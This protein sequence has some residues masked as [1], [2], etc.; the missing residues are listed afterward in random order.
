MERLGSHGFLPFFSALADPRSPQGR[1]HE[2]VDVMVIAVCAVVCGSRGWTDIEFFGEVRK[3]WFA[4]F[5]KLPHGI[6]SRDTFARIFSVLDAEAFG[7]C[8]SNWAQALNRA[9]GG[10][11]IAIDG[12]TLRRSFDKAAKKSAIHLVSA[13]AVDN[14]LVLGQVKV[15]SKSNEITAIPKLL[16]MLNLKGSTVT[17]D[18][19]GCQTDIAKGVVDKGGDYIFSLKGN[20]AQIHNQVR[21]F[22]TQAK[23]TAYR[24]IEHDA[25]EVTE[26]GHGRIEERMYVLSSEVDE[27]EGKGNW[28]NLQTIGLVDAKRTIG[29]NTTQEDRYFLSSLKQDAEVFSKAVRGH[30]GIENTLH[31]CLDVTMNEDQSRIRIENCAENFALL[32]KIA[33]NLLRKDNNKKLSLPR[34]QMLASMDTNYLLNVLMGATQPRP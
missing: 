15:D 28:M 11:H 8:F 18:A 29:E 33:L 31:W 17:I 23:A 25:W 9:L 4:T 26:K 5:L 10:N 20:H 2:L 30:W 24:E 1:R 22:F 32:R 19:M 7:R 3:E 14:Q 34:K 12:K 21:D 27:I 13:W 6:P 16:E